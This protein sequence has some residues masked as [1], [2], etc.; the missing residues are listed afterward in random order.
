M[1]TPA[2]LR[3][4]LALLA[5]GTA[6]AADAATLTVLVLDR[7]GKPAPNAVVTAVPV[8]RP[9]PPAAAPRQIVI[10]QEKMKFVPLVTLVPVGSSVR[11]S[12]AD[13]FEH[14]IKSYAPAKPFSVL[15]EA[16]REGGMPLDS[17]E[18]IVFDAPGVVPMQCNFHASMRGFIFVSD[19]PWAAVTGADG[20]V[21][22]QGVSE[23]EVELRAWHPDQLLDQAPQRV[24]VAGPAAR[25]SL[26]LNVV[27]RTRRL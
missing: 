6:L 26:Q 20:M 5:L 3:T 18:T 8:A 24:N 22:L 23:G 1:R 11:F 27:P 4:A 12:N 14:Q 10:T 15:M 16:A 13:R 17:R 19:T 9:L 21:T 25:A 2:L 7:D